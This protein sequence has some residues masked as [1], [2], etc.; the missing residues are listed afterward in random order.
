ML[1]D[2][3]AAIV[4]VVAVVVIGRVRV[5]R[6]DDTCRV[7]CVVH[8]VVGDVTAPAAQPRGGQHVTGAQTSSCVVCLNHSEV[9]YVLLQYGYHAV[10][11]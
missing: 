11:R 9:V 10:V 7:A 3:A 2:A 4:V 8:V 6:A 5:P 1:S